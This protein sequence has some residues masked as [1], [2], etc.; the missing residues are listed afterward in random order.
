MKEK[1]DKKKEEEK[2]EEKEKNEEEEEEEERRRMI[3]HVSHIPCNLDT[4][5]VYAGHHINT[6]ISYLVIKH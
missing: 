1:K 2:V 3:S 5:Q 4:Y 6:A